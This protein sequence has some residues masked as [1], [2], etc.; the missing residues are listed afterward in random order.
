MVTTHTV[1]I[2]HDTKLRD[3]ALWP[4]VVTPGLLFVKNGDQ[5]IFKTV[6][7]AAEV[8]FPKIELLIKNLGK[9]FDVDRNDE[10]GPYT[11]QTSEPRGTIFTYSVMC[12]ETMQ[13]AEGC[14]SPKMII[15]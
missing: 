12:T 2:R 3:A 9:N 8:W 15:E 10:I 1:I 14:S 7:T 13:F 4:N 5:I 11:V 6:G